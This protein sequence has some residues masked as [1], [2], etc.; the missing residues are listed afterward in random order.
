MSLVLS[1]RALQDLDDIGAYFDEIGPEIGDR[2]VDEI[3]RRCR[4]LMAHPRRGTRL[5][6]TAARELRRLIS[7]PYVIIYEIT[8][9]TIRIAR[10]LHGARDIDAAVKDGSDI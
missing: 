8:P 9:D 3:E 7:A 2:I 6:T 10:I 5:K 1:D 4:S